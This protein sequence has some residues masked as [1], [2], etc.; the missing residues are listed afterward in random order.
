MAR[1][2][3][4]DRIWERDHTVWRDD[5]TEIVDRLGWL[6]VMEGMRARLPELEAFAKEVVSDG[7]T[8]AVLLGMGGSSL[9]AEVLRSALG[10]ADGAL[11]HVPVAGGVHAHRPVQPGSRPCVNAA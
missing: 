4:V 10:A 8:T 1:D 9:A 5:P 11:G 7:L 6:D 3:V 2:G